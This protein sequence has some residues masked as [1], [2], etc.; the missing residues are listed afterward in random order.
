MLEVRIRPRAQLDLES[1]FL[2]IAI[3]ADTLSAADN[4]LAKI[5]DA[6]DLLAE[7]PGLG[8][9]YAHDSLEREYH[10]FLAGSY[11]VFYTWEGDSLIIWRVLHTRR[12]IDDFTLVD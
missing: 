9:P 10:R 12:D 3:D 11:W 8:R 7:S 2:H 6:I 5:Y 4:T 1:I